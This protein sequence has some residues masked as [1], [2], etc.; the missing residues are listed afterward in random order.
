MSVTGVQGFNYK[1][2]LNANDLSGQSNAVSLSP[3]RAVD[4]ATAFGMTTKEKSPGIRDWKGSIKAFLTV[5]ATEAL[6]TA[7]AAY[8]G[9]AAVALTLSPEGGATG[10]WQ[11]SGNVI[12]SEVSHEASPDG[13]LVAI[14][15]N[16]E[17]T[18][19]LAGATISGT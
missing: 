17:G 6:Q 14:T 15:I 12:V 1:V 3:T 19:T 11:W 5:G 10:D 2:T 8:T 4:D 16:F 18:G 9:E 13:G 7:W